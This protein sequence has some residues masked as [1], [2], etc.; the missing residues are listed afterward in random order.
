M[1]QGFRAVKNYAIQPPNVN[2]SKNGPKQNKER[3]KARRG[4]LAQNL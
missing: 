3:T 1:M 4:V 2:F